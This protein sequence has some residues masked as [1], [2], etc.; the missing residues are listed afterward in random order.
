MDHSNNAAQSI[1]LRFSTAAD[2]PAILAFYRNNPHPHVD[3]RGD[4]IFTQRAESGR[5]ILVLKPDGTI[6]MSSMS[7]PFDDPQDSN[8][9]GAWTEIG[10]TLGSMDGFGLYPFIIASQVVEEFI[11]RAPGDKFF[12]CIYK[13]NQAVTAMLNKKVGW[14]LIQP[15]LDFARAVGE[16]PETMNTIN[17]LHAQ[18]DTIPHQA[19]I[20]ATML[21][22]GCVEKKGTQEKL[23]LDTSRLSLA[24]TFRPQLDELAQGR[25]GEMLE[26]SGPLPLQQAR[27]AFDKYL[28]GATYFPEMSAKP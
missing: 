2:I 5:T 17:W 20:V 14:P 19:R 10:S 13:D 25:F 4:D 15:R 21:D 24:T 7:H 3:Y 16:K 28:A 18:S 8:G 1:S 6:A 26:N 12:A 23:V 9:K 22:K 11:N 27:K